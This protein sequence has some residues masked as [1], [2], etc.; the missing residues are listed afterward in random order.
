M[1]KIGP[2]RH[3]SQII[4]DPNSNLGFSD[5]STCLVST[6]QNIVAFS[7]MCPTDKLTDGL[8]VFHL[9]CGLLDKELCSIFLFI[10]GW[11]K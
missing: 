3:F 9:A 1:R 7:S 6:K 5:S 2:Q 8:L 4:T 10:T 11:V